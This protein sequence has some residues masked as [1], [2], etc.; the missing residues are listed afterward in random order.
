M[1][2]YVLIVAILCCG[3]TSR[4]TST[5]ELDSFN[6]YSGQRKGQLHFRDGAVTTGENIRIEKGTVVWT[7]SRTM[8]VYQDTLLNLAKITFN[9]INPKDAV[10]MVVAAPLS[11]LLILALQEEGIFSHTGAR[12]GIAGVVSLFLLATFDNEVV[13]ENRN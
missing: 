8:E 9:R 3:C 4:L 13:Y 7:D 6:Q 12:I 1:K 5:K 11:I 2:I 10:G